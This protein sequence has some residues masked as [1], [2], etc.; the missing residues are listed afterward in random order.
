MIDW[1]SDHRA[2]VLAIGAPVVLI[3]LIYMVAVQ[4]RVTA[5]RRAAAQEALL[6]GR[7]DVL[8]RGLKTPAPAGRVDA[9]VRDF[10]RRVAAA[11]RVPD[12]IERLARLAL[13][14]SRPGELRGLKIETG[15]RM[16]L[17]APGP[18]APRVATGSSDLPDPRVTLFGTGLA[19]ASIS[20][21]FEATYPALGRF[22][23]SLRDLPTTIEVR[24]L[25]VKRAATTADDDRFLQVDLVLFAFQQGDAKVS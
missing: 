24:S 8:Q 16:A 15:E 5:G 12:L 3:G 6:R 23:W 13:D 11:D 4:P 25:D 17:P 7:L 22:L 2:R 1:I 10:E 21:S 19:Y 20:V 14:P 18:N 9:S